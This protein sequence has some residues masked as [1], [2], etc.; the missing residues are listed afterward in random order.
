MYVCVAGARR[1]L[2]PALPAPALMAA[3]IA[4]GA[5]AYAMFAI[6]TNR[7]GVLEALD[8]FRREPEATRKSVS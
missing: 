6:A 5:N 1:L 7:N 8:L 2:A 3:L 4:T